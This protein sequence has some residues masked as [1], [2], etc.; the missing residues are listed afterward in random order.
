[1]WLK[2]PMNAIAQ[3]PHVRPGTLGKDRMRRIL[4][5][6]G[7]ALGIGTTILA[8]LICYSYFQALKIEDTVLIPCLSKDRKYER[9][10]YLKLSDPWVSYFPHWKISYWETPT[11]ISYSSPSISVGLIG[12]V[13]DWSSAEVRMQMVHSGYSKSY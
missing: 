4:K 3:G 1:M 8:L 12:T 10:C 2:L 7:R 13:I 11:D 9:S 5:T 6:L